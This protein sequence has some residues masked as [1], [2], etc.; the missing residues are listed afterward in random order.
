[1]SLRISRFSTGQIYW[2]APINPNG[3]YI[4]VGQ[5]LT[6]GRSSTLQ[7]NFCLPL[8]YLSVSV[9]QFNRFTPIRNICKLSSYYLYI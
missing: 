8:G 7:G 1:M 9:H 4:S 2:S 3:Q 6:F 5:R